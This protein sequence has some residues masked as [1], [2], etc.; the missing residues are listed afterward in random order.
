MI[1]TFRLTGLSF[2]N[3]RKE[4]TIVSLGVLVGALISQSQNKYQVSARASNLMEEVFSA[5][6]DI[7]NAW[8]SFSDPEKIVV[9]LIRKL[10][11]VLGHVSQ[12]A[13]KKKGTSVTVPAQEDN[14]TLLVTPLVVCAPQIFVDRLERECVPQSSHNLPNSDAPLAKRKKTASTSAAPAVDGRSVACA[15]AEPEFPCSWAMFCGG[16]I[17]E[18]M[19]QDILRQCGFDHS[20]FD[21][22]STKSKSVAFDLAMYAFFALSVTGFWMRHGMQLTPAVGAVSANWWTPTSIS[23]ASSL[24][25]LFAGLR[26]RGLLSFVN[27]NSSII[28]TF[29]SVRPSFFSAAKSENKFGTRD[30]FLMLFPG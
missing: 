8:K 30:Q 6:P 25:L 29:D 18:T 10:N 21:K 2:N 4:I 12:V 14:T 20:L 9:Y 7:R 27:G 19:C 16:R 3:I 5:H 11:T 1:A 13:K 22:T 28:R 15:F 26:C 24:F 23:A 17:S